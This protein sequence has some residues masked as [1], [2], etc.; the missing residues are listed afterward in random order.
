MNI[1]FGKAFRIATQAMLLLVF[2]WTVSFFFAN[3]FTCYPITP[4][5]EAFYGNNCVD[6]LSMWYAMA[7]TDIIIDFIILVM[8]IPMVLKLQLPLKQK[9][10]V[11]GMFLLGAL[12]GDRRMCSREN[13]A[14][15]MPVSVLSASLEPSYMSMLGRNFSFTSTMKPVRRTA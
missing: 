4:F 2:S 6:G 10:G 12:Y 8:P 5:I 7:I 1:F 13:G 15:K 9:L 14:D 3:L 11:L